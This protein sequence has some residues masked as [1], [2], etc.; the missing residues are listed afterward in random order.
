MGPSHQKEA[1]PNQDSFAYF[2]SDHLIAIAVADGLGSARHSSEG[3]CYATQL[4]VHLLISYL[5]HHESSWRDISDTRML[6][7]QIVAKWQREFRHSM[8]E[9]D[10][11][12][13]FLG[14]TPAVCVMGQL[15]DGLILYKNSNQPVSNHIFKVPQ[16]EFLNKPDASLAQPDAGEYFC[17]EEYP[18]NPNNDYSAFLLITDGIADDLTDP[19]VYFDDL[20]KRASCLWPGHWNTE[21]NKHLTEWP[22]PGHYDDKTLVLLRLGDEE[23]KKSQEHGEASGLEKSKGNESS[24]GEAPSVTSI[25]KES[26]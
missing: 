4:A 24:T 3:S 18:V 21:L 19:I 14:L 11:T 13:L 15:G 22:T 16:K 25:D 5:H 7:Q 26:P 20:L 2:H 17:V 9:Y 10:T 8:A 12:L 1:L 6:K 23:S